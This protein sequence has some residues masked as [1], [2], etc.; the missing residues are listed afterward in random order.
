LPKPFQ[1]I[2]RRITGYSD[3]WVYS[4]IPKIKFMPISIEDE[5][6]GTTVNPL[7]ILGILKSLF[8]T[9][10][11]VSGRL[12]GFNN[13]NRLAVKLES[14]VSKLMTAVW[15]VRAFTQGSLLI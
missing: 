13:S 3:W 12:L 7:E 2:T 8:L 10:L 15:I 6:G 9:N 1:V 4:R 14:V 5:W 11:C